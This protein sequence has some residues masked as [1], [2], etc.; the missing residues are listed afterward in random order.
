[1]ANCR[2]RSVEDGGALGW[3]RLPWQGRPQR[4]R[5][6]HPRLKRQRCRYSQLPMH[7]RFRAAFTLLH[8]Q[9]SVRL[10]HQTRNRREAVQSSQTK[11]LSELKRRCGSQTIASRMRSDRKRPDKRRP[12]RITI[13]QSFRGAITSEKVAGN[14]ARPG[15]PDHAPRSGA[16]RALVHYVT[17]GQGSQYA[18]RS[19]M[20]A[21][22]MSV[23]GTC[24]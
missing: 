10:L 7:R 9:E 11:S 18:H 23:L 1:V 5:R 21:S 3:I 4:P 22:L 16:G 2:T 24:S 17:D 20:L 14:A 12:F 19:P 8:K 6:R 15:P 13:V